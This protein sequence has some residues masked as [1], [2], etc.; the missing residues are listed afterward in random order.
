MSSLYL[1][2]GQLVFVKDLV[3]GWVPATVGATSGQGEDMSVELVNDDG[4][5]EVSRRAK[6]CRTYYTIQP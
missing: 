2:T 3:E 6:T 4:T 5:T 1:E